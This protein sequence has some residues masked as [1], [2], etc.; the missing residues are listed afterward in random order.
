MIQIYKSISEENSSLK[1]LKN[2]ESGCWINVVA[3]SDEE[4]LQFLKN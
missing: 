2:I 4:H 1:I 3:P